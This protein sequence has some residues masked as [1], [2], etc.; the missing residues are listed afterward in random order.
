MRKAIWRRE[1]PKGYN[2]YETTEQ[3]VYV[4]GISAE[5]GTAT[6]ELE[7]GKV[8]HCRGNELRFIDKPDKGGIDMK[9]EDKTHVAANAYG[10]TS[11]AGTLSERRRVYDGFIAGAKWQ[12]EQSGWR[13]IS[14]LT[15]EIIYREY[16]V[17]SWGISKFEIPDISDL[18]QLVKYY[19]HFLILP[20]KP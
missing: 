7:D 9:E 18:D 15:Q 12:A 5:Y 6:I 8:Y 2:D 19:T 17:Y 13:P 20:E 10:F 14:E 16:L 11:M 4:H 1:L 3:C